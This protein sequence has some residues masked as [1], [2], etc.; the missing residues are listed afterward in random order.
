M[1]IK[2]RPVLATVT[3]GVVLMLSGCHHPAASAATSAA[4]A[5]AAVPSQSTT[6]PHTTAPA[7]SSTMYNACGASKGS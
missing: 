2:T 7:K 1:K 6:M 3:M 5:A 4:P